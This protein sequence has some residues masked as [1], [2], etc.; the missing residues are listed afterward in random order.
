MHDLD[1]IKS[2][3]DSL[4]HEAGDTVLRELGHFLQ[5]RTRQEDI[6]CRYGGEEFTL[7]LPEASLEVTRQRAERLREDAKQ[8]NVE[9]LGQILPTV[10]LSQGVVA[11][12]EHG[13][14]APPLSPAT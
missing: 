10:S 12:P 3:N 4:G 1:H 14:T 2:F 9:Y 6:A 11:V 13:G 5:S 7:I 8:L